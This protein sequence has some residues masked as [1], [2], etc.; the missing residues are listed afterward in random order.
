MTQLH[1]VNGSRPRAERRMNRMNEQDATYYAALDLVARIDD[2][3]TRGVR[4]YRTKA[5]RLLNSLDEVINAI[6][7]DNLL[8][9]EEQEPEVYWRQELAA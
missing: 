9:P 2:D 7:S 1:I 4:H 5:G 8:L 3:L 6:L